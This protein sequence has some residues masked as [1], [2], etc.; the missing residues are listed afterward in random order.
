M[1]YYY[2]TYRFV[3]NEGQKKEDR[4]A[5]DVILDMLRTSWSSTSEEGFGCATV[6]TEDEFLI[7]HWRQTIDQRKNVTC[8]ITWFTEISKTQYEAQD[9]EGDEL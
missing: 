4:K 8:I 7:D 6:A 5:S 2:F 9:D 1:R 3:P